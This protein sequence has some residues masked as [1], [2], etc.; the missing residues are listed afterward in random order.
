V[1]K[2]AAVLVAAI[3]VAACSSDTGSHPGGQP[4]DAQITEAPQ[5][6]DAPIPTEIPAPADLAIAKVSLTATAGRNTTA[7]VTVKTAAGAACSILV[8]Y[9]SGP[10]TAAGLGDKTAPSSGKIT[11]S[12]KVGGRTALGTYPITITCSKGDASGELV[13]SFRVT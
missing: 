5:I 2:R 4:T 6:T 10:S 3:L 11:W 8:E 13:L 1:D 7:S 9:N 12:W